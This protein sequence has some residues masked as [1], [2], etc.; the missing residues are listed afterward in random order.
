MS[1]DRLLAFIVVGL[2]GLLIG[3]IGGLLLGAT[4]ERMALA[5]I[6]GRASLSDECRDQ[7]NAALGAVPENETAPQ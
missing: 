2:T 5:E 7:V 1:I 3:G 4:T 6:L